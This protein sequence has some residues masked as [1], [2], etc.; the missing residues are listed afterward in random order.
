MGENERADELEPGLGVAG[1][2][3][4]EAQALDHRLDGKAGAHEQLE[5][6]VK[7][8][9][10]RGP[11]DPCF[12]SL[13]GR[14]AAT[15]RDREHDQDRDEN[16][17]IGRGDQKTR[18]RGREGQPIDP[19]LFR[20]RAPIE[21]HGSRPQ[22]HGEDRRPEFRRRHAER[23]DADH[24]QDRHHRV[25]RTDHRPA[26]RE[27]TGEGHDHARLGHQIDAEHSGVAE[28][29]V[30]EPVGQRRADIRSQRQVV[31]DREQMGEIAGRRRI[32][33]R[34]HHDPQQRLRENRKPEHQLRTRA[35]C[36]DVER[37]VKHRDLDG[38]TVWSRNTFGGSLLRT[39]P[40]QK[41]RIRTKSLSLRKATTAL[42]RGADAH[43]GNGKTAA[44]SAASPSRSA[45]AMAT[46]ENERR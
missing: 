44:R 36:F 2:S 41:R 29:R 7:H 22:R 42:A 3:A 28:H 6:H 27:D 10:D 40:F 12:E 43:N 34:R 25:G 24:Q 26:E 14:A 15:A 5:M 4:G 30:G 8:S 39:K 45:C 35:Q 21:Q 46:G 1:S 20:D 19:A 32:Q 17:R 11:G 38:R 13:R 16:Q 33:Q 31:R 18:G 23:E 9:G 37:D